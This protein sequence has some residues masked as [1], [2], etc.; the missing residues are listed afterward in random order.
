MAQ[1]GQTSVEYIFM[2]V[3]AIAIGT[4]AFKQ[5]KKHL[6]EK[7]DGFLNQYVKTFEGSFN[8][9]HSGLSLAYKR[10]SIKR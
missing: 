7:P 3:V 6:I 4:A 5:L 1:K 10:F 8:H 2:M 9:D